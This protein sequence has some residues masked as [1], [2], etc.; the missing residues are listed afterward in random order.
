[1]N[2]KTLVTVDFSKLSQWGLIA[3]INHDILHPL[4]LSLSYDVNSGVSEGCLVAPD[5]YF[6]VPEDLLKEPNKRY[7]DFLRDRYAILTEILGI[8][9]EDGDKEGTHEDSSADC[10]L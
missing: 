6:E 7:E 9:D 8:K 1:M 2:T 4:G 3:K 5:L 10:V